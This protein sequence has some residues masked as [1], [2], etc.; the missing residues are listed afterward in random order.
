LQKTCESRGRH[1][2][3][4]WFARRYKGNGK[5]WPTSLLSR[6]VQPRT[7]SLNFGAGRRS[8]QWCTHTLTCSRCHVFSLSDVS[9]GAFRQR[10]LDNHPSAG[11]RGVHAVWN[12]AKCTRNLVQIIYLERLALLFVSEAHFSL[13]PRGLLWYLKGIFCYRCGILLAN[14][15][16]LCGNCGYFSRIAGYSMQGGGCM[17]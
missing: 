1:L 2:G 10:A 11:R 6:L 15:Q 7:L 17:V 5:S 8:V 12:A 3:A 4:V 13:F 9:I 14:V 16:I